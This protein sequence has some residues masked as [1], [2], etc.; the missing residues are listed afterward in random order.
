MSDKPILVTAT[1]AGF[2]DQLRAPGDVFE[3]KPEGFSERWMK[4]GSHA[5]KREPVDLKKAARAEALAAG[6]MNA[7]LTTAL[8]DLAD[9]KTKSAALEAKIAELEAKIAELQG[10]VV[11]TAPEAEAEEQTQAEAPEGDGEE[12]PAAPVQRVRRT[13]PSV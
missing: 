1:R 6:G 8:A 9:E 3:V 4:K 2:Y 7:A 10:P 12:Q 13:P 11:D 5:G